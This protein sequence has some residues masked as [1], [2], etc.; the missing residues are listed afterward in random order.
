[1]SFAADV[2]PLFLHKCAGC[3][4]FGIAEGGFEVLPYE[5]LVSGPQVVPRLSGSSELIRRLLPTTPV[6]E[7]MPQGGGY[8]TDAEILK[9]ADWIDQ[10]AR[11]N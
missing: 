4:A 5:K 1:M 8:L 3:H 11:D 9:V 10:G 7:R 6:A 2:E